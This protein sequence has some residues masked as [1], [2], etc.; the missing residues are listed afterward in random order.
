MTHAD[1]I[2]AMPE[3][4]RVRVLMGKGKHYGTVTGTPK[5]APCEK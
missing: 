1:I 4:T 2:A 3:G 5:E